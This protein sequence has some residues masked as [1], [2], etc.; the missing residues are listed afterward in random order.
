M[1]P[2]VEIMGEQKWEPLNF[3]RLQSAMQTT[4]TK[5]DLP[6]WPTNEDTQSD[7]QKH[8]Q[9]SNQES[10]SEDHTPA[11]V[12]H[13]HEYDP[14]YKDDPLHK[15]DPLERKIST[16]PSEATYIDR[17]RNLKGKVMEANLFSR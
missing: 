9:L 13:P 16:Q 12:N 8:T 10:V 2:A 4:A 17:F 7:S 6:Q 5:E 14:S 15:G 11:N 3:K 1:T